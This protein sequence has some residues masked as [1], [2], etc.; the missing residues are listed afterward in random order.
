M[1]RFR[2]DLDEAEAFILR[3]PTEKI[4]LLFLKGGKV[5]Q[6]DPDHLDGYTTHAGQRRGH[7]PTSTEISAAMFEHCKEI[8]IKPLYD[9]N[10]PYP[11]P[12]S[13]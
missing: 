3:M 11:R 10:R 7:W 12:W 5:V 6:P 13:Q 4:G 2:K 8:K 1:T 9:S